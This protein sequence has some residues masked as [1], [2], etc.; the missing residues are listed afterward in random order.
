MKKTRFK[1]NDSQSDDLSVMA[2]STT[3]A[4]YRLAFELNA[5]LEI[6]LTKQADLPVYI[7]GKQAVKF[8]FYFFKH[9]HNAE[10]YLIEDRTSGEPMMRSFLLFVK[11]HFDGVDPEIL[12]DRVG[13]IA[14]IFNCNS[15][16]FRNPKQKK[17]KLAKISRLVN[18]I[19]SDLEYHLLEINREEDIKKVK[20][21]PTQTR[22]IR[23]LYN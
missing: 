18:N 13:G 15:I 5:E 21:K 20:L 1:P 14:D 23:K 17:G 19:L 4:D 3:M 22:S 6:N 16:E 11:G 7:S 2:I 9:D 12:P 8:P 10:C